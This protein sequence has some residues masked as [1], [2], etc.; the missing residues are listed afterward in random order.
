VVG[1]TTELR[2]EIPD[3][4]SFDYSTIWKGR[5]IEDRAEKELVGR[6]AVGETGIELGGGFGRITKVLEERFGKMFMLDYSL[7][8]LRKASSRLKKTTLIRGSASNL[9]F[10]DNV[11]DFI[12]LIRVMHHVADPDS[13]LG[14]VVRVARNGG[15]FILGITAEIGQKRSGESVPVRVDQKA[16]RFI[17]STIPSPAWPAIAGHT[18][19][20]TPLGRYGH[21][22][23]ERVEIRGVG[24]FDNRIGRTV[25]RLWPLATLDLKTSRLW[26]A[27]SMLF[28][29]FRVNKREGKN[30]PQVKCKCGG[31]ILG[32]RCDRCG[33]SY[34]QIIDLIED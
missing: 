1:L 27:K 21:E 32:R 18:I 29:R 6:W 17:A 16:W 20:T 22:G 34:G 19:Y 10:D 12:T 33:R 31:T 24:A 2:N 8:N 30:A 23:L 28:V 15:T 4:E 13:L 7:R 9:P 25:E 3:Y 11:F 26:P 14:E 5:G